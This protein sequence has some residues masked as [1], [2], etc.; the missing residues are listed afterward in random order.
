MASALAAAIT[1]NT[2]KQSDN[3]RQYYAV[4]LSRRIFAAVKSSTATKN[5]RGCFFEFRPGPEW[6]C[7]ILFTISSFSCFNNL[8]CNAPHVPITDSTLQ[9]LSNCGYCLFV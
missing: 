7:I 8:R 1:T 2:G 5:L 6:Y 3:S 9:A 4:L